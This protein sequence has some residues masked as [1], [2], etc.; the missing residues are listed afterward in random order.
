MLSEPRPTCVL[1]PISLESELPWPELAC[2]LLLLEGAAGAAASAAALL[3]GVLAD[4]LSCLTFSC[5]AFRTCSRNSFWRRSNSGAP[6]GVTSARAGVRRRR[7]EVE[8]W[9]RGTEGG[10]E[11]VRIRRV[12]MVE[13]GAWAWYRRQRQKH[14]AVPGLPAGFPIGD[15]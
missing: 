11:M 8:R 1:M 14:E 13:E 2:P 5:C 3:V 10:G 6:S 15:W 4:A 7:A 9:R 12:S